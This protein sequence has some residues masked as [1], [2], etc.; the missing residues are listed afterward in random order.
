MTLN[1]CLIHHWCSS[2]HAFFSALLFIYIAKQAQALYFDVSKAT[3]QKKIISKRKIN[4]FRLFK[5][6]SYILNAM[7]KE[8]GSVGNDN[9]KFFRIKFELNNTEL[10]YQPALLTNENDE[11]SFMH[12][13]KCLIRDICSIT[14]Q[15]DRIAQ[16][17]SNNDGSSVK[18]TYQ[19]KDNKLFFYFRLFSLFAFA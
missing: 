14:S 1:A 5:S 7:K 13:I 11:N 6:L 4:R 15:I 8:S 12:T 19:C 18:Q 2:S 16:L 3:E 10:R 9:A 17:P